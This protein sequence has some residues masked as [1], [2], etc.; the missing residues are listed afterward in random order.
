MLVDGFGSGVA[1]KFFADLAQAG[2]EYC[3]FNPS[4]GRSYL[5]RNHQ[6][7]V[8]ADD[9]IA[10][11]GGAN[12]DDTYLTD[13]GPRHWRD[14]WLRIEGGEVAMASRYFDMIFRWSKRD[15]AKLRS[16]KCRCKWDKATLEALLARWNM[17][18]PAK[19]P[20]M[21]TP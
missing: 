3:V 7:L 17:D 1:P 10:I 18:S 4:Y 20:P 19:S 8:T 13:S 15:K 6:K 2:G 16:R 9:R 21:D 5:L 11:L 14:L 12:I